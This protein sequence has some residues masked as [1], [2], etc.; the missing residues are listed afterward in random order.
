M[1]SKLSILLTYRRIFPR[2]WLRRTIVFLGILITLQGT[3]LVILFIFICQPIA[4]VFNKK[5]SGKCLDLSTIVITGGIICLVE[6]VVFISLPIPAILKLRL[7]TRRKIAV[8]SIL[9][10]GI[11]YVYLLTIYLLERRFILTLGSACIASMIRL[12]YIKNFSSNI[13]PNCTC[14]SRPPLSVYPF[15]TY[16]LTK[17]NQGT[18]SVS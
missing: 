8:L 18:T 1:L 10:L 17:S 2:G 5:L 3:I 12:K 6:D 9:C 13:D 15:T 11:V 16:L 14:R 7:P 4:L